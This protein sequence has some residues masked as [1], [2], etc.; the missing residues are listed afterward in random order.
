MEGNG[1]GIPGRRD[2][3][4][5]EIA[6]KEGSLW[7]KIRPG[8]KGDGKLTKIRP[9]DLSRHLEI[10]CRM[11][12]CMLAARS[13]CWVRILRSVVEPWACIQK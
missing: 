8:L 5:S 1:E 7:I 10:G 2:F 9:N 12:V 4:S 3:L 11:R 6:R 13:G